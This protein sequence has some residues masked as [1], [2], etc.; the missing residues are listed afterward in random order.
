MINVIGGP[1]EPQQDTLMPLL[2]AIL[3]ELRKLSGLL[4]ASVNLQQGK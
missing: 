1:I 4:E 2:K 3:E